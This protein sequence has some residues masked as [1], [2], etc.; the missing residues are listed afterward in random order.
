[1]ATTTPNYGWDV[2]TST[3]Y[4]KDG[5]TAIETLGDDIDASMFTALA[6]K[7]SGLIQLT[8]TTFS[9]SSAV[10]FTNFFSSSYIRYRLMFNLYGSSNNDLYIRFREN[11]TDKATTYDSVHVIG[12][13]N[14]TASAYAGLN[15]TFIY[16]RQH[17]TSSTAQ[18]V[19]S[20]DIFRPAATNGQ[21]TGLVYNGLNLNI[22]AISGT[23]ASMTNFTGISIIPAGGTI[24]GSASLYAYQD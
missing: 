16:G 12:N 19:A 11:T 24:T 4:V 7:K 17:T 2:P 20:L 10:N 8:N 13:S 1:M 15:N 18:T 23:N 14:A 5:A 6:G 3:D 22:A 21:L 9:A